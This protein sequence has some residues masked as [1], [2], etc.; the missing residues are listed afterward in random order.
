MGRLMF[1]KDEVDRL[2]P[3]TIDEMKAEAEN[4]SLSNNTLKGVKIEATDDHKTHLEVHSK[5]KDT[6]AK[7]A[8]IEAH[9][10]A[11]MIQR[12]NPEIFAGL[13]PDQQTQP[14][15][16]LSTPQ[17]PGQTPPPVPTQVPGQLNT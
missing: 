10:Q 12:N 6:K 7:F 15:Q 14:G 16:P 9:K 2:I 4:E 8:H 17:I 1:N 3:R 11:M 5:A 13:L